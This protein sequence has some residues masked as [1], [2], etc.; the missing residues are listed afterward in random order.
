MSTNITTRPQ[1][2]NANTNVYTA[3]D[4]RGHYG[5]DPPGP[6]VA[7]FNDYRVIQRQAGANMS[8]DVGATGVGLMQAWVRGSTR[9]GQGLYRVDNMDRAAPT[10]TAYVPQLNVAVSAN[11]SGNPRLDQVVLEVLDQQHTGASSL[12]RIRV[13]AGTATAGATLDNRAGAAVLPASSILLA[14]IL[15]ANAAASI[16]TASIRDRRQFPIPGVLPPGPGFAGDIEAMT[17]YLQPVQQAAFVSAAAYNN[18]QSAVLCYLP[19]RIVGA[20]RIRWA[21]RQQSVTALTGNVALA[22]FD[23]SAR[24]VVDTGAQAITGAASAYVRPSLT[25]A[26][27]T[28]EAGAYWVFAGWALTAGAMTF[29]GVDPSNQSGDTAVIGPHSP[30]LALRAAAG[31]TVVPETL[32]AFTDASTTAAGTISVPVPLITLSVG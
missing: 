27:T 30:N 26:A 29:P 17:P 2:L 8:V 13:V 10:T 23:A 14:D 32:L 7:G 15:V 1:F 31:G 11:A 5:G 6:G 19:R 24:R 4:L 22:I 21:Y 28:F 9:E 12:A 20:T 18:L 3:W 16:L 25:I